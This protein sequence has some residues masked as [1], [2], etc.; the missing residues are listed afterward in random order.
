MWP[1]SA[2]AQL[3]CCT[4]PALGAAKDWVTEIIWFKITLLPLRVSVISFL[5]QDS[6][7]GL[8]PSLFCKLSC[9]CYTA[10]WAQLKWLVVKNGVRMAA[11]GFEWGYSWAQPCCQSL[12]NGELRPCLHKGGFCFPKGF[13][14]FSFWIKV[15]INTKRCLMFHCKSN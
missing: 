6:S 14:E 13:S 4:D 7:S 9:W 10:T 15:L 1:T 2:V 11:G 3:C 8:L 5:N 12:Q